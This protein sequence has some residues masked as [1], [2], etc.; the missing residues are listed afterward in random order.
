MVFSGGHLLCSSPGECTVNERSCTK[1]LWQ[2]QSP[3]Y[4]EAE[5]IPSSEGFLQALQGDE[6]PSSQQPAASVSD[7]G[8]AV[9]M[10]WAGCWFFASWFACKIGWDMDNSQATDTSMMCSDVFLTGLSR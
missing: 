5:I 3:D 6:L 4:A 9:A 10:W 8:P 2:R 7:P 1:N